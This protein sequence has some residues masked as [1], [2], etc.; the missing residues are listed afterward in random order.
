MKQMMHTP[1]GVRDIYNSEC[2]RKLTIEN[3]IRGVMNSYGYEDIQTPTF[4]FFEIFK[5]ER[6]SVASNEMFKLFDSEG[7]T[8]VLR[9]DMT[10][11]IVRCVS[12]YYEPADL[13]VRLCYNGSTFINDRSYRLRLKESTD[14]GAELFGD[15]S[16]AADAEMIACV[17]D[18]LRA[19]GLSDFQIDIGSASFLSG[20]FEEIGFS[21]ETEAEIRK[22]MLSKNFFALESLLLKE[23]LTARQREVFG[24][25]QIYSGTI[26]QVLG[27][28][29][30]VKNEKSR[31]AIRRLKALYRML[32]YYGMEKYVSF[33][34]AMVTGYQYYTG[35]IF[36]AYTYGTGNAIVSGGRY[37]T[38]MSQFSYDAPAV[39]FKISVDGVMTALDRQKISVDISMTDTLLLMEPEQ[40]ENV[41]AM[42]GELRKRGVRLAVLQKAEEKKL[43]DYLEYAKKSGIAQIYYINRSGTSVTVL[44][45]T[46][47]TKDT[48]ELA[49][50]MGD[51]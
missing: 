8:L 34:L 37:D 25:L 1:E 11:S 5:K 6:G 44:N 4:E 16:V 12:K 29:A 51:K 33:D 23:N 3:K 24:R 32:G 38:L 27:M 28:E 42:A 20:L 10:P 35:I 26:Q 43:E 9:P 21:E 50:L 49:E 46:D 30:L 7:N 17:V 13:P 47:G 14:A 2:A 15:D 48:R 31:E 40:A 45:V 36:N 41:I 18:C 19:C 22:F 39:G